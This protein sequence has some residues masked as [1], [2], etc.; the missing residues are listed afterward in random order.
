MRQPAPHTPAKGDVI[1]K[2][3]SKADPADMYLLVLSPSEYNERTGSLI[4]LFVST[5]DVHASNPFAISLGTSIINRDDAYALGNYPVTTFWDPK[6]V[7][8]MGKASTEAIASAC[9]TL[10]QI[11]EIAA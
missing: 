9:E 6:S 4:G 7:A 11:I 8:L 2:T 1:L 3:G 10:N 5:Q